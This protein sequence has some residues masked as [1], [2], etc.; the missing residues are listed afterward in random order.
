MQK[1]ARSNRVTR[2]NFKEVL[3]MTTKKNPWKSKVQEIFNVCQ[4]EIKRTT[5][6]GKRMISASQTNSSLQTAY[7]ELGELVAE[8]LASGKLKWNH[9]KVKEHLETI[10]SCEETLQSIEGE[11]NNIRFSKDKDKK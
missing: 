5:K 8:E 9:P 7:K 1:V 2:S 3:A 4:D 6:I 10:R 11:V